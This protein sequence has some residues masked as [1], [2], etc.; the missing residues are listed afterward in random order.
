VWDSL[1]ANTFREG[2][3]VRVSRE[4]P[5]VKKPVGY[6]NPI[7][8]ADRL[9]EARRENPNR[10]IKEPSAT[11][12][13]KPNWVWRF[14]RIGRLPVQIKDH[15]RGLGQRVGRSQVTSIDLHRIARLPVEL[16]LTEFEKLLRKRGASL[17]NG[18]MFT[19]EPRIPLQQSSR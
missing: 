8:Q 17:P 12:G 15:V 16:Q 10:S 7:L 1:E 14:L 18:R 2:A 11:F 5:K 13:R 6:A 3:S 4:L 9:E 19:A